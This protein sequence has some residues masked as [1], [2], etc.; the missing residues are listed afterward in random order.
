MK[1][2]IVVFP[3]SWSE[4]DMH[5]AVSDVLGYQAEYVWHREAKLAG[6]D[7]ILLPGGFS[8]GD[9][10]RCGAV[11]AHSPVMGAIKEF[12]ENGGFVFGSCNGFQ[13]LC[14]SGLLPGALIRNDHLEF[15][16]SAGTLRVETSSTPFTSQFSAGDVVSMPISHGE[17]NYQAD[18]ETLATL[19]ASGRIVFRYVDAENQASAE[20][21]PNGSRNNIAGITNAR[22]NVLGM[23]P[24]PERACESLLGSSDGNPL[25]QS[26]AAAVDAGKS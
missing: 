13:I 24:H 8:Y 23:M 2:G 7:A 18:D 22:G 17:G 3:G 10:L 11:A 16:C 9:H 5:Y 12:V 6:F 26:I 15:R 20:A 4:R 21:N 14:E 25:W 1:F 19:E